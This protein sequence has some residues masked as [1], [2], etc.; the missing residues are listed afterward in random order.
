MKPMA[1]GHSRRTYRLR[2]SFAQELRSTECCTG[3]DGKTVS[4]NVFRCGGRGLYDK[5]S[6]NT[7]SRR[8][9]CATN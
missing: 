7:R 5:S 4:P 2:N 6:G 3:G 1:F 8:V 9:A